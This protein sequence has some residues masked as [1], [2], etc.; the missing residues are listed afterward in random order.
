VLLGDVLFVVGFGFIGRVYRENTYTS[1]TVE[2][3]HRASA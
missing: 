2:S 1:A 3:Q